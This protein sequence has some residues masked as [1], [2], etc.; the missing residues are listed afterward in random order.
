MRPGEVIALQEC[1]IDEGKVQLTPP[2]Y[3][4]LSLSIIPFSLNS[5]FVFSPPSPP[6]RPPPPSS[7]SPPPSPSLPPPP[8]PP[9]P[10]STGAHRIF[11]WSVCVVE[12]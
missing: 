4:D 5:L 8:P 3:L 11:K 7:S 6:P 12:H 1:P 10:R 2:L 9:P